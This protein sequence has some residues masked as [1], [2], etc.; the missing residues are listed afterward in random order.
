M[1]IKFRTKDTHTIA[2]YL[3][4]AKRREFFP[5]KLYGEVEERFVQRYFRRNEGSTDYATIPTVTL[6]GD[7]AIEF[8]VLVSDFG[9]VRAFLG[10]VL[11]TATSYVAITENT[12]HPLIKIGGVTQ[13]Y[14]ALTFA[15]NEMN[16][17]KITRIGGVSKVT[18]NG[19]SQSK[20]A[21]PIPDSFSQLFGTGGARFLMKGILSNLKIYDNGTLVR[22]YP[23]ND[24]G[25]TL[26]DLAGGQNGTI[27]NGNADDWGL[28][29]ETADGD[30]LGQE[31]V[32]NGGFN[33]DSGWTLGGGWTINDGAVHR[34]GNEVASGIYQEGVFEINKTYKIKTSL[35][36][37]S[38][39]VGRL[40]IFAGQGTQNLIAASENTEIDI[41]RTTTS[42]A[43]RLWL[44]GFNGLIADVDNVSV[45]EVL[46]NA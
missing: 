11:S 18:L 32:V 30:W 31:L 14:E 42:A 39:P 25:N 8:D 17:I 41:I 1:P 4:T 35:Y 20:S 27:I 2:A 5:E 26:I 37:F 33:D 44:V 24:N 12:G 36:N 21:S 7:F 29:D 43:A 10:D 46:K 16:K 3:A 34:D 19:V 28:F 45:K 6:S 13:T 40:V 38:N 9:G 15:L 23:M 22:H